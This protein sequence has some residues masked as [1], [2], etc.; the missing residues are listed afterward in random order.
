MGLSADLPERESR[1]LARSLPRNYSPSGVG[2]V[3]PTPLSRS[4]ARAS[5]RA[6][7]LR[8]AWRHSQAKP[9]N[10]AELKICAKLGDAIKRLQDRGFDS[11]SV[12]L[13]TTRRTTLLVD[14]GA[15]MDLLDMAIKSLD[16]SRSEALFDLMAELLVL[17]FKHAWDRAGPRP[18]AATVADLARCLRLC[19]STALK[20]PLR[21]PL[22]RHGVL[23]L[24]FA[25][26]EAVK[27]PW[28][29]GARS[30]SERSRA[31]KCCCAT[32]IDLVAEEEFAHFMA[33]AAPAVFIELLG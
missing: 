20:P 19:T 3:T 9:Q 18:Q 32:V 5:S 31:A 33:A 21:Q 14:L 29:C 4:V 8:K 7:P 17:T 27:W 25:V 10:A 28:D 16:A 6:S 30:E 12:P 11:K 2:E 26:L 13:R 15:E 24:V 1:N 22:L 23:P